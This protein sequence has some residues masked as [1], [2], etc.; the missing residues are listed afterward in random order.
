MLESYKVCKVFDFSIKLHKP[1]YFVRLFLSLRSGEDKL[2]TFI[3]R[4]PIL[5]NNKSNY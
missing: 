5:L 1:S 3:G 2:S 4:E